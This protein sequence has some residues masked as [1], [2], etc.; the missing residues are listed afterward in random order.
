MFGVVFLE[1]IISV[2]GGCSQILVV[3]LEF[4]GDGYWVL[5]IK[6][7]LIGN[8]YVDYLFVFV[9]DLYGVVWQFF[10]LMIVFGVVLEDDWDGFG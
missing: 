8:I 6:I 7:Y 9:I 1:Q 5:G 10:I 4:D 2:V 3:V